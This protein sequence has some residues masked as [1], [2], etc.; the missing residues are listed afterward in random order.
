MFT[1]VWTRSMSKWIDRV[2]MYYV[3][4][5]SYI[6]EWFMVVVHMEQRKW[7]GETKGWVARKSGN[8]NL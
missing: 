2:T 3:V 5:E 6:F 8:G 7:K 4:N 1:Y